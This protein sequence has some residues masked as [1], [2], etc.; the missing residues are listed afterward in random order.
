MGGALAALTAAERPGAQALV[1]LAPYV[2]LPR[3]LRLVAGLSRV[4]GVILPYFPSQDV[5]SVRDPAAEARGL[6]YGVF[7]P[8]AVRALR[9]TADAAAR[10]L[11]GIRAPTLIIQSRQDNRVAPG[12][13]TRAL[14]RIAAPDKRLEW[15]SEGG[16]VITVD[17]G[18]ERV[19]A[20][21]YDWLASHGAASL[22]PS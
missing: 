8:A 20:L 21:T 6:A 1:L 18:R 11:G 12:V 9:A 22:L 2:E 3:A 13:A 14:T 16:H 17:Y 4:I 7:T 15:V 10:A 19:F 5:R